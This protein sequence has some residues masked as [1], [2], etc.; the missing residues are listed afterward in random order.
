MEQR[1]SFQ[2]MVLKQLDIHMQKKK[3]KKIETQTLH[4]SEKLTQNGSQT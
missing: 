2:Q 4:P 1:E 3:K